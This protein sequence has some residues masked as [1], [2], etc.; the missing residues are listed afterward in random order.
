[1]GL[2][3]EDYVGYTIAPP[4]QVGVMGEAGKNGL[5][6]AFGLQGPVCGHYF[7]KLSCS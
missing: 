2:K 4:G 6:G 1:M 7:R 3:G 5:D